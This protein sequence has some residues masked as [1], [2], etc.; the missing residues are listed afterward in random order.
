MMTIDQIGT[1]YFSL[2]ILHTFSVQFF[3]KLSK[4]YP[5]DSYQEA[6]FHFLG[7]IE[8]VFGIWAL[9]FIVHFSIASSYKEAVQYLDSLNFTEPLFVFA[10]MIISASRPILFFSR[11]LIEGLASMIGKLIPLEQKYVDLFT[12]MLVGPLAG[13]FITEPAAMTVTALLLKD[14]LNHPSKKFIYALLA[15]LF[16]NIS[17]GGAMTPY[18][19]PPILMVAS[20]WG[21]DIRFTL[22]HFAWK[23]SLATTL[24]TLVLIVFCFK[25][26]KNSFN[27]FSHVRKAQVGTSTQRVPTIL[28]IIHLLFL[29]SIVITAH[30]PNVFIGIL[31]FFI[32]AT[33]ATKQHQDQLRFKESLLVGF[34]LGG[35]IVFGTFQKWWLQP[36]LAQLSDTALFWGGT[37]LTAI[38]DN[39]ALTYLGSQ[40]PSLSDSAKYALVAGAI[41]GGGLTVIA[42]APNAAGLSIL[43]HKFPNGIFNPL[44]L[45]VAALV[46]TLIAAICL[47]VLPY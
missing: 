5:K 10:V 34:F 41:T 8:C 20:T 3:L 46:P 31:L 24:N 7:E 2:A 36:L 44:G 47:F 26:I 16:V 9:F 38:T 45:F 23:V 42:N 30:H 27:G 11:Q 19:A 39:A 6:I 13:S 40:V 22:E 17:I 18:A 4:K 43:S 12:L 1:L 33:V 29:A 37:A 21:W 14:M 28:T 35:I 32:G 15:V 25:D